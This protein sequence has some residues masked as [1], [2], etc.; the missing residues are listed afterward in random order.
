MSA[1]QQ[2]S[3]QNQQPMP[4]RQGTQPSSSGQVPSGLT[5]AAAEFY[6]DLM[7]SPSRNNFQMAPNA[8]NA[9]HVA[10][11][12]PAMGYNNPGMSQGMNQGMNQGMHPG[13]QPNMNP[14]MNQA[15]NQ[16]MSQ[17][18]HPGMNHGMHPGMNRGQFINAFPQ[19]MQF[20]PDQASINNFFQAQQARMSTL[21]QKSEKLVE[22]QSSTFKQM[23]DRLSKTTSSFSDTIAHWLRH[24]T[25]NEAA[26][27]YREIQ[28]SHTRFVEADKQNRQLKSEKQVLEKQLKESETKLAAALEERDEQRQLADSAWSG[29]AKVSDDAVQSKWKQLD[30]N[31]R[32]MARA[33]AKCQIRCVQDDVV[34]ERFSM[35]H[36]DW[37][38]LLTDDNHKEFV[39]QAYLWLAVF[40]QVFQDQGGIRG[41]GGVADLKTMRD[42]L[43]GL[44]PDTDRPGRPGPSLRHVARWSAQG[45]ALFEHF[46]GR[47]QKAFK[48]HAS[49]E[50]ERLK[51][52][53]DADSKNPDTDFLQEMKTV[54]GTAMD[55]D[56]MLMSSRAVF[57]V[58]W[59]ESG[60]STHVL[61]N[62]DKMEAI[63]Y[64]EELSP[65]TIVEI[66]IS[67]MLV[68]TGN[69]DGCNYDSSMVLAKAL[70]VCR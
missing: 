43:V 38:K 25:T 60:Q 55:L 44:A 67:P 40:G 59:N 28:K 26:N 29:S 68:K 39:I 8:M 21:L 69:A 35:I 12:Q 48:R 23:M 36:E 58:R 3:G 1:Q 27:L 17:A 70:A 61:F 51:A 9:D 15:M 22:S 50:L 5:G 41:A 54:L 30:Y 11:T 33:L 64:S 46:I 20:R 14:N 56:D 45:A 18:M 53:C 31:I 7:N 62:G 49:V 63:A 4:N 32:A 24:P 37:Q 6:R 2:A 16:A 10:T 13:M 57:M 34:E 65:K 47:N 42:T 66:E 52:F 19:P